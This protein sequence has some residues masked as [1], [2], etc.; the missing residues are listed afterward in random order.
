MGGEPLAEEPLDTGGIR[1]IC[2]MLCV[3]LVGVPLLYR[4]NV[5]LPVVGVIDG[6]VSAIAWFASAS[7]PLFYVPARGW[8][9][10]SL[11]LNSAAAAATAGVVIA[12]MK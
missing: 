3:I 10:V 12:T 5:N 1:R 4:G 7:V 11:M 8:Y 6:F 2:G 9:A